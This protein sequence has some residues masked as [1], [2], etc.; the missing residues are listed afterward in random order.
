MYGKCS[1][2]VC[3]VVCYVVLCCVCFGQQQQYDAMVCRQQQL[4]YVTHEEQINQRVRRLQL[5]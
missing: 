5:T 4:I 3:N 1:I 2:V